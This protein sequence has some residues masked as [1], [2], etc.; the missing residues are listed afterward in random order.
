MASLTRHG[1]A[2]PVPG[3]LVGVDLIAYEAGGTYLHPPSP[4]SWGTL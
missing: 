3:L 4:Q 1:T 2:R